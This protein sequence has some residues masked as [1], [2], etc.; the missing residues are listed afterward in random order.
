MFLWDIHT[1]EDCSAHFHISAHWFLIF[2]WSQDLCFGHNAL[3]TLPWQVGSFRSMHFNCV[4][5]AVDIYMASHWPKCG[6]PPFGHP[7][8]WKA[9]SSSSSS[10]S[11]STA[12]SVSYISLTLIDFNQP[13]DMRLDDKDND[14]VDDMLLRP[15]NAWRQSKFLA[16]I[17][18]ESPGADQ[19][20]SPL[21]M[22]VG[23]LKRNEILI[24][25]HSYRIVRI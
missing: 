13:Q 17:R 7:L 25:R 14:N 6:P 15:R 8:A 12:C 3:N 20:A 16:R 24:F 10:S 11:T 4:A 23:E 18:W 2:L 9:S 5:V 21:I 22:P 1:I 19:A